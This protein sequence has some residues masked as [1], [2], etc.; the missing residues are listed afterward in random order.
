MK[1]LKRIRWNCRQL[2]MVYEI[3]LW[4]ITVSA[5]LGAGILLVPGLV[6][7]RPYVILSSSM[8][9]A[10]PTGSLI[11]VNTRDR[12][13]EVGD[14]VTFSLGET[15]REVIVTHRIYGMT[16]Q[17]FLT[18]GDHNDGPDPALLPGER[19]IG[20]CMAVFPGAGYVTA[21]MKGKRAICAASVLFGMHVFRSVLNMPE[22]RKDLR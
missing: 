10:I 12:T 22:I 16:D 14:I 6:G 11:F 21:F 2:V 20:T 7:V 1:K 13:A 18:K 19:I 17:G 4:L 9:P 8:E 15:G 5:A 3:V